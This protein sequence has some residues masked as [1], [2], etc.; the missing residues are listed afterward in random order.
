MD[1][2]WSLAVPTTTSYCGMCV[3]KTWL[4][5]SWRKSLSSWGEAFITS[6]H[7]CFTIQSRS[8]PLQ[9]FSKQEC[10]LRRHQRA[11]PW[12]H[13]VG[14]PGH[15]LERSEGGRLRKRCLDTPRKE[16]NNILNKVAEFL[17]RGMQVALAIQKETGKLL[18]NFLP[19]AEH[20]ADLAVSLSS[21]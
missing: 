7:L 13:Q 5:L 8:L 1:T 10:Y 2:A 3:L 17:H 21:Q 18:K 15:D 20:N 9:H 16:T 12:R 4:V 14:H 19:A 11:Q 6:H